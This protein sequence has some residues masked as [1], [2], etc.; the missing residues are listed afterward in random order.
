MIDKANLITSNCSCSFFLSRVLRPP[1]GGSNIS[2]GADEE[3]P[4]VRKNKMASSVFAEPED[5]YANRRNNPPGKSA[6][7]PKN[8]LPLCEN[9]V[10]HVSIRCCKRS[11][12]GDKDQKGFDFL[13]KNC[14]A[15]P[16]A[17]PEQQEEAPPTEEPA[18]GVP[19]GRRNPPGGKS[20]LI[21]G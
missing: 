7:F 20:S 2:L 12:Y 4:P 3:K 10:A 19:S 16:E 8:V 13:E 21:L 17:V 14:A 18:A 11:V 5:P 15:E 6:S 1:G 9:S